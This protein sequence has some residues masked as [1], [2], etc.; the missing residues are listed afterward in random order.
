M[1]ME[2]VFGSQ[3]TEVVGLPL[4]AALPIEVTVLGMV[5]SVNLQL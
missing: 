1:P 5:M 4:K 2:Q 3:V